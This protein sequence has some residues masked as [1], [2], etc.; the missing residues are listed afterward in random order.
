MS[1]FDFPHGERLL[2]EYV[3]KYAADTPDKAAFIYYGRIVTYKELDEL[4]DRLATAISAMGYKKGD[5]LAAF[6]Q[7][8]AMTY[9]LHIAAIKLG[10]V[11]VPI[12]PMSKELE[13]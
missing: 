7:S 6:V 8:C 2:S 11:M 3:K 5:F 10:L 1:E 12:D 4:S 9:I 13:L